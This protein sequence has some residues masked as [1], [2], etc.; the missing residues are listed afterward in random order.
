MGTVYGAMVNVFGTETE[1]YKNERLM[2]ASDHALAIDSRRAQEYQI[3]VRA[4]FPVGTR[5][6]M[7]SR[8]GSKLGISYLHYYITTVRQPAWVIQFGRGELTNTIV[9]VIIDNTNDGFMEEEFVITE[10]HVRRI[11]SVVGAT[12]YSLVLRNCEHVA[13][14]IQSGAWVCLQ[15]TTEE[16]GIGA[17]FRKA[18]MLNK[19]NAR[20]LNQLPNELK[21]SNDRSSLEQVPGMH[22]LIEYERTAA[23]GPSYDSKAF[24]IVVLGP[25]GSGKSLFINRLFNRQL[26]K[27]GNGS[28][29]VTKQ[30]R[31]YIGN[32]A[33]EKKQRRVNVIDSRGFCD[34]TISPGAVC[35]LVKDYIKTNIGYIDK[36]VI[37]VS[38]RIERQHAESIRQILTW[39][40]FYKQPQGRRGNY[41]FIY[42]KADRHNNEEETQLSIADMMTRL[43]TG[44][45]HT[46]PRSHHTAG[47]KVRFLCNR[48]LGIPMTA[49]AEET[50]AAI[51]SLNLLIPRIM[52]SGDEGRIEVEPKSM[53]TIL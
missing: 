46:K 37:L 30:F 32:A 41:L 28:E 6:R 16:N 49:S 50:R 1:A 51:D 20:K 34:S 35:S 40:N 39:L 12:A 8:R 36:L 17:E 42:N 9:E 33:I 44:H 43:K 4:H 22:P 27:H 23:L 11:Q 45:S 31:T 53:C 19:D 48:S 3:L 38:G 52:S 29:S 26:C 15:M 10:T 13:R 25:T 18:I 2:W 21:G 5:V 7:C 24:N 47:E 14:Y